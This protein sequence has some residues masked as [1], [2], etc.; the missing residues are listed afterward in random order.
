M[1]VSD[2]LSQL[3]LKFAEHATIS[4]VALE[5]NGE[6]EPGVLGVYHWRLRA[7]VSRRPPGPGIVR[8]D[9]S[10]SDEEIEA[11]PEDHFADYLKFKWMGAMIR[12][13]EV[14]TKEAYEAEWAKLRAEGQ[15]NQEAR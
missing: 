12:L 14:A 1:K 8:L 7:P 3:K 4:G 15:E 2:V 5:L 10:I 9:F 6:C 13:F 11:I